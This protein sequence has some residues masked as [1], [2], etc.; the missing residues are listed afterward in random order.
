[1]YRGCCRR[2]S[3]VPGLFKGLVDRLFLDIGAVDPWG[4][5]EWNDKVRTAGWESLVRDNGDL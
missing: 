1:M 5:D 3:L 2:G 4:R